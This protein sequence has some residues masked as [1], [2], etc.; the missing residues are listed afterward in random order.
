MSHMGK[1]SKYY[2][3][4]IFLFKEKIHKKFSSTTFV[5]DAN[6]QKGEKKICEILTV[7]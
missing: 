2:S 4:N 5:F 1:K 3:E 7:D 6:A